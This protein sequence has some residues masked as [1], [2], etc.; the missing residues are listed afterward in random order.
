MTNLPANRV[1][2]LDQRKVDW[3]IMNDI[4]LASLRY[5][6]LDASGWEPEPSGLLGPVTLAPL[7]RLAPAELASAQPDVSPV[8]NAS[9]RYIDP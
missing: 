8:P 7:K 2:D 4:N 6:A 9:C 1:R 5:K 3:K